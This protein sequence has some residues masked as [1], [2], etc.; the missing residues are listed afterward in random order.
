[1]TRHRRG[2]QAF[3]QRWRFSALSAEIRLTVLLFALSFFISGVPRVYTQTAAHT[4]FIEAFGAAAMPWAYLAQAFCVPA[5]GY[6][7]LFAERRLGLRALL[8]GTLATQVVVLLLFRLGLAAE[9]PLVVAATI[10]YF[11]IEFVLSS[12]LLWG[13]ANQLMNLRQGK[14]MF[15]FVSAGEPVAI[16][17]C[18]M[19]TPLL[20]RGLPVADLFLL[21][22]LGAGVGIGLVLYI[23]H[24]HPVPVDSGTDQ[25]SEPIDP[26]T[27]EPW[28][29][30]RYVVLMVVMVAVGQMGYFLVDSA[31][32]IELGRRFSS[33]QEMASFLGV[34][35]AVMGTISLVCSVLLAPWL[36]RRF[37][38]RGGLL[39][40]PGLLLLGSLVTVLTASVGGPADLLFYLVVGNKVIDQS[41]RYTL[42]KTTFVTLFQPLASDQRIR[43][44]AGLESIVEPLSGGVAGLLLFAMINWI[45]FG[46]TG[47]TAVV[48]MVSC[49]WVGLV[50]VQYRA[51]LGTLRAAISGRKVSVSDLNMGD[52]ASRSL[53][54]QGLGSERAGE[55]LFCLGA[56]ENLE[57]TLTDQETITLLHHQSQDVRLD[58][59]RRIERG[60]VQIAVDVLAGIAAAEPDGEV[61]G[62][63][64]EALAALAED[65]VLELTSYLSSENELVRLGACTGLIR[66][67]GVEGVLAVGPALLDDLQAADPMRRRFAAQL[68]GRACSNHFYRPLLN[69]LRDPDIG[70]AKD[71]LR[72]A[73]G[74]CVAKLWPA[75][76]SCLSQPALQ[77]PAI[78]ALANI[79]D[80]VLPA[81]DELVG[82]QDTGTSLRCS[83][84]MILERMGTPAAD[85]R[86]L[87]QLLHAGQHPPNDGSHKLL[88]RALWRRRVR[89]VAL[90]GPLLHALVLT[91]VERAAEA[92]RAWRCVQQTESEF[93]MLV[94]RVAQDQVTRCIENIFALLSIALADTDVHEAYANYC[95]G[96]SERRA[97]GI[98]MLDSQIET[99]LKHLVLPLVE[100]E[101]MS[102]RA[103]KVLGM[104]E[105]QPGLDQPVGDFLLV[106]AANKR[107][108][109]LLRACSAYA[110][111]HLGEVDVGREDDLMDDPI[112]RET[113]N[114]ARS[115]SPGLKERKTMLT[116]E[117]ML[118][119]RSAALF[120]AVREEYIASAA[121]AATEIHLMAGQT[122]F[123]QGDPGTAMFVVATGQLEVRV[124]GERI[125]VIDE[126]EVVGEMA[127]LDPE[128]RSAT[129]I[130]LKDC[131]LLQLTSENLD[132]LMGEDVEVGRGIIQI[133]CRRLRLR[134]AVLDIYNRAEARDFNDQISIDGHAVS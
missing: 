37:G 106:L 1:M 40:L 101:G 12:L 112:W 46:S 68:M 13:L 116:I 83:W 100:A 28:W 65:K 36:L 3:G 59:A 55:V 8:V 10:V 78:N 44:Q 133:L 127:V 39:T 50:A 53:L 89:S 38:V 61:K 57:I 134:D 77:R 76:L 18:G 126:R 27:R 123:A 88:L 42:D 105:S 81:L 91:E 102:E 109:A 32:Y 17:V 113:S 51:Y 70:V 14:R 124:S 128:P 87:A 115:G 16:I 22:A 7:Y 9:M 121:L 122:L 99:G 21:S 49:V 23:L 114:W 82:R 66:H 110:A 130:A 95:R 25:G 129:V 72:A 29:R 62:A 63:L 79:G 5:A 108:A 96:G 75:M 107:T 131:V 47:I 117:K 31:F 54:R 94:G 20:L 30:N 84:V 6:L 125:S 4:L 34:Y 19:S 85:Q 132:W 103:T 26:P 41:F 90:Q 93:L 111:V 92:L 86:L 52:E 56:L 73:G 45:G 71:A 69:L 35:S 58:M 33:E 67:G 97:Y 2:P 60:F 64:L 11:E 104:T 120:A 118:I 43:V 74:I 119:L 15:S 24:H 98:E 48:L 80:P